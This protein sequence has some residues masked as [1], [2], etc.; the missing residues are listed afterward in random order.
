MFAPL[1][2]ASDAWAESF[3]IIYS[4]DERIRQTGLGS[5][6]LVL[7]AF[8]ITFAIVRTITHMIK[9]GKGPFG[10]ISVGGTHVHH[11]VPGIFL[12]LA[13]GVL[14]IATGD[15][16]P[17]W[18][19]WVPPV[20]FGIGAALTLDEFALWLTLKDVYWEKEGRRS[21]DAVIILG[22]VLGLMALGIP[23]WI[24]IYRNADLT[25]GWLVGSYHALSL[26]LAVICFLKGKWIFAPLAI[27]FP[28]L[29]LVGS[30]R[31]ARPHST[32]ARHLYGTAKEDRSKARYPEDRHVPR[33][34]WQRPP[35]PAGNE[36]GGG[37]TA[38]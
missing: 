35:T 8:L 37:G 7:G 17:T 36:P 4:F 31:L 1:L 3:P 30:L 12:L 38:S 5:A 18:L 2:P 16:L 33:W 14:G 21:V 22:A 9:A 29:G 34:P 6:Q 13:S 15:A 20:L 11:L 28:P 24:D 26:V 19:L 25:G 27:L 23:F 10:N 32:W